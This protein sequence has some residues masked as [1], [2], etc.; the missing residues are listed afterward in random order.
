MVAV[1]QH[2]NAPRD[3]LTAAGGSETLPGWDSPGAQVS[4]R[5]REQWIE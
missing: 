5:P 4:A 3:G 1:E 2:G